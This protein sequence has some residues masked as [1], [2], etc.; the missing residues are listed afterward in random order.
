MP[1]FALIYRN[2]KSPS[3]PEEGQRHMQEWMAWSNGLGKAMIE[4]GMPFSQTVMVSSEGVSEDIGRNSLNGISIVEAED[5]H[6][7]RAMAES[8]PHMNMGGDIVVAEG[9]DMPMQ[10]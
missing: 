3:S 4:P 6:A 2:A 10:D 1:R 8:C 9:M 7:A 5:C